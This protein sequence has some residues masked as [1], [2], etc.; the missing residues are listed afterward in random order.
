MI[1]K[2]SVNTAFGRGVKKTCLRPS[3]YYYY[4]Y[5]VSA[6]FDFRRRQPLF[7]SFPDK[8]V[9]SRASRDS[10]SA[11]SPVCCT[12]FLKED[13]LRRILASS[14]ASCLRGSSTC[15]HNLSAISLSATVSAY[16]A[17]QLW[18]IPVPSESFPVSSRV[19]HSLTGPY[20]STQIHPLTFFHDLRNNDFRDELVTCNKW[21]YIKY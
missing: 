21:I 8:A 6:F 3:Y 15:G 5:S 17:L 4:Y 20:R 12:M 13:I 7:Q 19:L 1:W 9:L 14:L 16:V 18:T 2:E 11:P 10:A